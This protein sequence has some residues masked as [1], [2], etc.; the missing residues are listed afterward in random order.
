MRGI[1]FKLR[2]GLGVCVFGWEVCL[3]RKEGVGK[4]GF[5]ICY[6]LRCLVCSFAPLFFLFFFFFFWMMMML[7]MDVVWMVH[8]GFDDSFLYYLLTIGPLIRWMDFLF[9]SIPPWICL[10]ICWSACIL[11]IQVTRHIYEAAFERRGYI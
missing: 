10:F 11:T 2:D 9:E 7:P 6:S 3:R 1:C 8:R 4:G 5:W